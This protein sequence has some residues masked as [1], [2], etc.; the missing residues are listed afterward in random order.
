MLDRNIVEHVAHLARIDLKPKE[1]E[2]L[3]DQVEHIIGFIDKLKQVN[4]ENVLPTSYAIAVTNVLREDILKESLPKD[5]A[6]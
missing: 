1:L 3:S 5:K 4:V 2:K 6:L